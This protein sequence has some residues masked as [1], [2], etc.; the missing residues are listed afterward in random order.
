M[1]LP[2]ITLI[3]VFIMYFATTWHDE[4]ASPDTQHGRPQPGRPHQDRENRNVNP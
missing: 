4:P 2:L 3:L 1:L